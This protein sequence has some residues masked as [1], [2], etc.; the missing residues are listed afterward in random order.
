MPKKMTTAPA[1]ATTDTPLT[2]DA[3]ALTPAASTVLSLL[4]A[5]DGTTTVDLVER[6]GL[7]RSTVTK[8]L[9]ALHEAGLAVRQ[10]GGH[11]GTRR[12]A[13]R[14][15]A[16][17][18]ATADTAAPADAEGQADDDSVADPA[19]T[20]DG[21]AE[22][23]D[24]DAIP[25]PPHDAAEED[26]TTT[27]PSQSLAAD[28]DAARTEP[29]S[30]QQ[31]DGAD[32][33]AETETESGAEPVEA[34]PDLDPADAEAQDDE[35]SEAEP[36]TPD[37]IEPETGPDTDETAAEPADGPTEHA[38]TGG[39]SPNASEASQKSDSP[40]DAADQDTDVIRDTDTD[41]A[42]PA[43]EAAE[44]APSA[45]RLGKGELRA[46]VEEHLRE[47]PDRAWTPTAISKVLNRSAGAINNACVKLSESGVVTAFTDKPIRFQWKDQQG[48]DAS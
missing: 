26:A 23:D 5:H 17:P 35:L 41:D 12:I 29:L 34:E 19:E 7:G 43:P 42:A 8:A 9:V 36:T 28:I 1:P 11:E 48:A 38:E 46:Q 4:D 6:T 37:D 3:P 39:D 31:P 14:W 22:A 40:S 16:A 33:D 27:T 18:G 30:D 21:D 10:E 20:M 45:P 24:A 13:D 32:A 2:A 47:H 44:D 15:F 25:A